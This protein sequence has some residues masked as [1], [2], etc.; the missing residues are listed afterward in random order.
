MRKRCV[1]ASSSGCASARVA[2]ASSFVLSAARKNAGKKSSMRSD[3]AIQLP[4]HSDIR[5]S[6]FENLMLFDRDL[7]SVIQQPPR[8]FVLGV[9]DH[10]VVGYELQTCV[11]DGGADSRLQGGLRQFVSRRRQRAFDSVIDC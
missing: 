7:I 6:Q 4:L 10:G 3:L 8:L 5:L 11:G 9:D 2:S 1:S